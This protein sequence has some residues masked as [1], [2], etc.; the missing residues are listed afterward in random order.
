MRPR[1]PKM[2][3]LPPLFIGQPWPPRSQA[4]IGR[5]SLDRARS[6]A[7]IAVV[8]YNRRWRRGAWSLDDPFPIEIWRKVLRE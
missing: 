3:E 8:E 6:F 5:P 7:F 1:K 2:R 4:E